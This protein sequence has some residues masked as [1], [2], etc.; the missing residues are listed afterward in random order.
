MACRTLLLGT[1]AVVA[2]AACDSGGGNSGGPA[3]GGGTSMGLTCCDFGDS[4]FCTPGMAC[5][6]PV[7]TCAA[8]ANRCCA[9]YYDPNGVATCSCHPISSGCDEMDFAGPD[10]VTAFTPVQSCPNLP[11]GGGTGGT[12]GNGTVTPGTPTT[13]DALVVGG[14]VQNGSTCAGGTALNDYAM[15]LCPGGRILGAGTTNTSTNLFCGSYTTAP[16]VYPSCTDKVGCFAKVNSTVKDTLVLGG[17]TNVEPNFQFQML[18]AAGTNGRPELLRGTKCDDGSDGH[19]ILKTVAGNV[20]SDD[21]VSSTC[22]APGGSNPG[23]YGSCGTDCDCGRCWYCESG[24]CRYGG[25][26]PYG[27][28]RGC[29]G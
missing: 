7:T 27:C 14:Y 25:E 20:N 23:E 8:P 22:P 9:A 5:S 19:I 24:T 1:I 11:T 2:I 15:F 4:C 26:G 3:T 21:C 13:L 6:A 17:Q 10:F 28:Y 29:S 12:G 16:P 18:V